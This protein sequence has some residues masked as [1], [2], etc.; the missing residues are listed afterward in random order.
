MSNATHVDSRGGLPQP[1]TSLSRFAFAA[2]LSTYGDTYGDTYGIKTPL[3]MLRR[4][5]RRI[6]T[7]VDLGDDRLYANRI[8]RGPGTRHLSDER[9][10][11]PGQVSLKGERRKGS[12][13]PL[14]N[15]GIS[16]TRT[17]TGNAPRQIA[18][19]RR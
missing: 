5:R 1:T 9:E 8:L 7:D 3:R 16:H 12:R 14:F 11:E 19:E 13:N 10:R 4:L 6:H 15:S 2:S 17:S 18:S